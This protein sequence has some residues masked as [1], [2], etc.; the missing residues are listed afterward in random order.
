MTLVRQ[1]YEAFTDG[2][3][4][5]GMAAAL[6]PDI[7]WLPSEKFP[8][9]EPFRGHEG[10]RGFVMLFRENFDDFWMRPEE[11]IQS[12]D[13]RVVVPLRIGGHGKAGGV[14]IDAFYVHVWT[15]S[16]G[17]AVRVETYTTREDALAAAGLTP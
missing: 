11:F 5:A 9:R 10:V 16:E 4:D 13:G 12:P 2:D 6:H 3:L 8:D 14:D 17:K 1:A 7:E 15:L